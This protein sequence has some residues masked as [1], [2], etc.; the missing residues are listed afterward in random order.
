MDNLSESYHL[1]TWFETNKERFQPPICN[2]MMYGDG[3][4]KVMFVGGPNVRKDYHLDEGEEFFFQMK[5]NA[6]LPI[7]EQGKPKNVKINEGYVFLLPKCIPHSPQ[8]TENSMGLVI[9]RDRIKGEEMDGMCWYCEPPNETEVLY[10]KFFYCSNLGKQLGPIVKIFKESEECR[11]G[12]PGDNIHPNPPF[13]VD[14]KTKVQDPIHL[15]SW[16]EEHKEELKKKKTIYLYK[17]GETTVRVET[18]L[19]ENTHCFT[20]GGTWLYQ[21][22]GACDVEF[23]ND[24]K[25]LALQEECCCYIPKGEV[26]TVRRSGGTIGLIANMEPKL[27]KKDF[28]HVIAAGVALSALMYYFK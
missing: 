25:V 9:E 24:R 19:S 5:G 3:Q 12:I 7:M 14:T 4:L 18:G 1:P 20:F 13:T 28:T 27:K 23:K 26:F 17:G 11:T 22:K 6:E 2:K 16:I 8:R 21:L 15:E 10:E